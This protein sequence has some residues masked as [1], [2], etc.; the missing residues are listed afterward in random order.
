MGVKRRYT[1]PKRSLADHVKNHIIARAAS[2]EILAR[3]INDVVGPNSAEH[4]QFPGAVHGCHVGP[5]VPGK[6]HRKGPDTA[7]GAINQN[8]LSA[9]DIGSSQKIRR[10]KPTDSKG[11][12][13]LIAD[14]GRLDCQHPVFR[15]TDVLRIS[16]HP[17][18]APAE[19]LVALPEAGDR[20]AHCFDFSGQLLTQHNRFRS[21]KTQICSYEKPKHDRDFQTPQLTVPRGCGRRIYP[22]QDFIVPGRGCCDLAELKNT[23]RPG[24]CPDNC[25]HM[26]PF[27]MT[28][29]PTLCG[30]VVIIYHFKLKDIR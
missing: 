9:L 13:F 21:R 30:G 28:C 20:F 11:C 25:F 12:G 17:K 19:N 23:R 1:A 26:I 16:P 29:I 3:I 7:T 2:G 5:K 6:L 22:D 27:E 15:Q 10:V 14:I 24:F 8:L 18:T 4:V